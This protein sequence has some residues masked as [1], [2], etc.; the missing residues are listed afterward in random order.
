VLKHKKIKTYPAM[1]ITQ[2]PN[3]SEKDGMLSQS[4]QENSGLTLE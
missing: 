2:D 4:R 1:K 3:A